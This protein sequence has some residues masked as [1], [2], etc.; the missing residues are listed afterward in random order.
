MKD[1][2]WEP[3]RLRD[4][5]DQADLVERIAGQAARDTAEPEVLSALAIARISAQIDA[6]RG[7]QR[8]LTPLA[9]SL[10]VGA[11]L[12]GI[13]TAAS[14][15]HLDLLPRW[16]TGAAPTTPAPSPSSAT[17][18]TS[19]RRGPAKAMQPVPPAPV[20]EL[21]A[22]GD[23][24]PIAG[25]PP[26][27]A[28][29]VQRSPA[30]GAGPARL[31]GRPSRRAGEGEAGEERK[32]ALLAGAPASPV[33]AASPKA[34]DRAGP[35]EPPT[36]A[37]AQLP[38]AAPAPPW[39]SPEVNAPPGQPTAPAPASPSV[40]PATKTALPGVEAAPATAGQTAGLLKEIVRALRVERAPNRALAL[41]DRHRG[42]LAG[43]AF[44]EEALLLRV[45]AMLALGERTA[46]LRLLD[47]TSLTDLAVSSTLLITRGE[48]RAAAHR[49][50]EGIG[51]FD[52]VL[53]DA[54]RP[55]KQ[56]LLGRARCK[57]QLGDAAGADADLARSRREFPGDQGPR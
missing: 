31:A 17:P 27:P 38:P 37:A 30:P 21:A 49:C 11:F 25:P 47:R 8:R 15:A 32:L 57:Q 13:V 7:Q 40:L 45:E 56:A 5:H 39:P 18:G 55:S 35:S 9:W 43:Q 14:A 19:K 4:R 36:G 26:A 51:D 28:A 44:A 20:E 24:Q 22:P 52:L 10:A 12:L 1:V 6:R 53:A 34:P 50:A 2:V 33:S 46:V 48:L 23:A 29:E 54:R 3:N 42:E 16:L 41:L